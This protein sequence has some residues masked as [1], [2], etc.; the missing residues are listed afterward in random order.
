MLLPLYHAMFP[1][2]TFTGAHELPY[3][4]DTP[5]KL[6]YEGI[7][8]IARLFGLIARGFLTNVRP[9]VQA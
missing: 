1:F 9:R 8:D 7:S 4:W 6:N 3:A 5:D 2:F